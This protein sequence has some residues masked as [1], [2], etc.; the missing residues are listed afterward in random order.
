MLVEAPDDIVC[1]AWSLSPVT[2]KYLLLDLFFFF[3][4]L[5]IS[6][7]SEA[8]FLT[9][10]VRTGSRLD[11][12]YIQAV[13]PQ[14]WLPSVKEPPLLQPP[15]LHPPTLPVQVAQSMESLLMDR[16]VWKS[17]SS[18]LLDVIKKKKGAE[19]GDRVHVYSQYLLRHS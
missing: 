14:V 6:K 7:C 8:V 13:V 15:T 1:E 4:K 18:Y 16:P 10:C 17:F 9:G 12:A 19:E 3:F 11:N 2:R 5:S